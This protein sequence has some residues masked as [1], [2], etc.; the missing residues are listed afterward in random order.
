MPAT[1]HAAI[2]RA[3]PQA[4]IVRAAPC[5]AFVSFAPA[6]AAAEG[7]RGGKL[8]LVKLPLNALLL[9]LPQQLLHGPEGEKAQRASCCLHAGVPHAV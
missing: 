5:A 3:A 8:H 1:L 7:A 9:M 2:V 4:A 6:A